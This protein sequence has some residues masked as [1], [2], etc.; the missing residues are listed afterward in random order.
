MFHFS[1]NVL[2]KFFLVDIKIGLCCTAS[3]L[4]L[5]TIKMSLAPNGLMGQQLFNDLYQIQL[6]ADHITALEPF[7]MF[8]EE[9]IYITSKQ[10]YAEL[11]SVS[12][13]TKNL[14]IFKKFL[15]IYMTRWKLL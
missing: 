1:C 3:I 13:S 5:R 2:K 11:P 15:N 7:A 4:H 6:A 12:W 10:G 14:L 8:E 9:R